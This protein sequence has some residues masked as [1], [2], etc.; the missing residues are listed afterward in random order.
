MKS[1]IQILGCGLFILARELV[2]GAVPPAGFSESIV[3]SGISNPTAME[4]APDGRLFVCQQSGQLRVI[5]N[6]TLLA[7]PF[8]SVTVDSAGERGLLGITFDPNF[9]N[10]QFVYIYY[11]VPGATAHNRISRFIASGDVASPGSETIILEL[12]NLS[13]ASNHNGGAIHFGQDGKLYAGVGENANSANAQT[14]TN[15]LGKILRINADGSIPMD[16]PFYSTAVGVN[17]AI[18]ALGLRNPFT[19]GI[20]PGTGRIFLDDVGENTWEEINDSISGA[21]YGWPNCEGACNPSNPSFRDP[22]YQYSH[23]EGCAIAGGTFYNPVNFQFP[24]Q[25][26]GVYFFADLCGGWIRVLEPARNNQVSTF[27]TGAS[28]PVDLKVGADGSLYYL[29]RGSSSVRRVQFTGTSDI[30]TLTLL[31]QPNGLNVTFDGLTVATPYAVD[32]VIGTP[33]NIGAPSSQRL[34]KINYRFVRWSDSGTQ[35]HTI[36]TPATDSTYSAVYQAKG[37]P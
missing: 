4:F 32:S 25:Y 9:A 10:N 31:T 33:H 36:T 20:Q 13:S 7:T 18:W 1:T 35:T 26:A 8:L 21:N 30:V 6:G 27:A 29:E 28:S 14:L 5:K 11:T 2:S 17:R 23:S 3:A 37:H 16:N 19:F 12:N 24:P 22:I 34:N 15:L